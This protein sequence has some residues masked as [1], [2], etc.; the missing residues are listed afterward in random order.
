ME[1]MEGCSVKT[2]TFVG[3]GCKSGV[4][5]LKHA[6]SIG[7][8]TGTYEVYIKKAGRPELTSWRTYY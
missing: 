8:A 3:P 6:V 2:T 5:S 4:P 7:S 1:D